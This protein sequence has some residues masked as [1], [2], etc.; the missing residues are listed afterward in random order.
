MFS[1]KFVNNPNS[2][3]TEP[4]VGFMRRHGRMIACLGICILI[5]TCLHPA[6]ASATS[7]EN[8]Y[9]KADASYR[10][11]LKSSSKKKYRHNWLNC[12]EKFQA[13]Y[14]HDP[15]GPWAAAGL[16]MCGKL[17]YGLSIQSG[18]TS[19]MR[20]ARD[21]FKRIIKRFPQSRYKSRSER[22][23]RII[24]K[25][26]GPNSAAVE[27]TV[28]S[29]SLTTLI[30][31]NVSTSSKL[32]APVGKPTTVK[33]LRYWSNPHYTRVVIDA[34]QETTFAHKYLRVDP[35]IGKPHR[36]FVDL[37]HSRVGEKLQDFLPIN[38]ELLISARAGQNTP[39]QVRV[40]VDIKSYET[41]KVFSLKNPFRIVIDVWGEN[42][43][44]TKGSVST[45][46]NFVT[47]GEIG[48]SALAR[49]FALG[50]R[51]II[52]DP[53]H[54]GKD[55]GA[56][57]YLKGVHEKDVVLE[58]SKKLAE[59][60]QKDLGCEVILTR[61][62]DRYL[63]LEE[64]TAIANTKNADLFISIHTNSHRDRRASGI[65]TYFLNLATDNDA[66]LV[67]ARENATSAKNISDLQSILNDLMHNAKVNESSR[68]AGHVQTAICSGLKEK[69]YTNIRN[70]GVKQAPFYVLLGAQMPAILVETSFISNKEECKR[71][72][73]SN[74]QDAI[75]ESIMN[76]VKRYINETNPTALFGENQSQG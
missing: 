39:D 61:T 20:Q 33:E 6:D 56:P 66:I 9:Y 68:L 28:D 32:P 62:T 52:V 47:A 42:G 13:V 5:L 53:G 12:I 11:L 72:V 15:S 21:L 64:R 35:S 8:K 44:A 4:A 36:L 29:D 31:Q 1:T 41:Y 54:G 59:K 10:A 69:K 67:A 7:A 73:N 45:Q 17:Y 48:V 26:L 46:A 16:F 60:I 34:D 75:V 43:D 18:L 76:G 37:T 19:D 74:Y 24:A 71:L 55:Y 14:D 23:L 57:G 27:E 70:K 51:R 50:V 49:Q 30:R 58:I 3:F 63:T 22:E 2:V 38:D 65:E 25:K 40:V